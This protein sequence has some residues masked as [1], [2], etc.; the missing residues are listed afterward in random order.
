[1]S[2]I[3]S[4]LPPSGGSPTNWILIG[5]LL[6]FT[7]VTAWMLIFLSFPQ[8]TEGMRN[9]DHSSTSVKEHLTLSSPNS[10]SSNPSPNRENG[11]R[12]TWERGSGMDPEQS[13]TVQV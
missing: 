1:M 3:S 7:F 9:W 13:L 5:F 8:K 6:V 12:R 4:G 11:K 2:S 10:D